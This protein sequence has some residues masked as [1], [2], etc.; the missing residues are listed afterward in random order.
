MIPG[1]LGALPQKSELLAKERPK[2]SALGMWGTKWMLT[3]LQK[4]CHRQ[5]WAWLELDR[6][7]HSSLPH[8]LDDMTERE[9]RYHCKQHGCWPSPMVNQRD[10]AS[11][12]PFSLWSHTLERGE[13][14]QAHCCYVKLVS[15][16]ERIHLLGLASQH[17]CGWSPR[18]GVAHELLGIIDV[19][20]S[21]PHWP[22]REQV[23][24]LLLTQP[25]LILPDCRIHAPFLSPGP[26]VSE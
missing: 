8:D 26:G 1:N 24:W 16:K 17:W 25:A 5:V 7:I 21:R 19:A 2:D 9:F 18:W 15:L 14:S 10:R 6:R 12:R 20:G 4:R 13:W 22:D 11:S 3:T 23:S